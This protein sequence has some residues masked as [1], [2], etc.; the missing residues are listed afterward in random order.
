MKV[1]EI[2][3]R[4]L[5]QR[6][7]RR[8][9]SP[10]PG[11]SVGIGDDTAVLT[12]AP[13]R[14]LLATT[15]LVIESIHFRRRYATPA[16]IGWKA[17][18]VNLSD[19][20]A[21][22]G[23]PRFALVAFACAEDT[24]V[25]EIDALYEG[26]HD[27]A[28]PYSVQVVGGDT[29]ASPGGWIVNITLLGEIDGAPRLRSAARAG[30][31]IAVTGSL[32]ASAAGLASF[33]SSHEPVVSL[34]DLEGVRRAHLRPA[35]RVTEGSWLGAAD[36]VHAMID[37]S[38]GLAADLGHVASESGVGA[39]VWLDRLPVDPPTLRVAAALGLD[40]LRLAAT[41]GE[42]YELVV[43]LAPEKFEALAAGLKAATGTLLTAIGEILPA[44]QGLQFLDA[45]ERPVTLGGGFEHFSSRSVWRP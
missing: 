37:C 35:P 45:Q 3:E 21:M 43:T 5:I 24:S 1:G 19:I 32:G 36:G 7:R 11:V 12:V 39:R 14:S 15:D 25:E 20:A 33:E 9:G 41:G 26:I 34:E 31:V 6:V 29:S 28:E 10:A 16:D 18:A 40:P 17:M 22:G 4:E 13:A 30:D 27:A 38:D 2:G 23:T 8:V 42:D 44:R